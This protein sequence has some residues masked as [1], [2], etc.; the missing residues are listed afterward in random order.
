MRV[1][2]GYNQTYKG[3]IMIKEIN[4]I[5][6]QEFKHRIGEQVRE[7]VEPEIM[8]II[9]EIVKDKHLA[10]ILTHHQEMDRIE[11]QVDVS[12]NKQVNK[13]NDDID[14]LARKLSQNNIR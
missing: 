9:N 11:L 5:I 8:S 2:S 3:V 4:N 14:F 13:L 6:K 12:S 1:Y 10:S 7:V